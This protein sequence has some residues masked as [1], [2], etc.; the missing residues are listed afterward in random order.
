MD[1]EVDVFEMEFEGGVDWD[2]NRPFSVWA[3]SKPVK[4]HQNGRRVAYFNDRGL[5]KKCRD[6]VNNINP[7]YEAKILDHKKK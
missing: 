6:K 7:G 2:P 3:N 1:N 4:G 5:A